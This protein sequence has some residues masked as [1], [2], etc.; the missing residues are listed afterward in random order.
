MIVLNR[1]FYMILVLLFTTDVLAQKQLKIYI[2]ADMEGVAGVV[3]SAQLGPEGF[4][5]ER[6]REFMSAEV[7]TCITAL[8]E[9]G[10]GEILISDSHGNGQ[11]LLIEKFPADVQLVRA[12]PRPLAMMQGIDD[13]F[14]GVIFLG[15]HTSTTNRLG[16][17]AHTMSSANLT[18]VRLNGIEMP[19][20]G[21]NAAIAGQFDVPVIMISGDDAII[22]ETRSLLGDVE[23]AIV[24][25]NYGFHSAKVL[26]PEA[27]N[28]VIREKVKAAIRRIDE[29]EPYNLE[30]PLRLEVSLKNYRPVELLGYLPIVERIDSHTVRF[31]GKD[32]E[33]ISRFL[34]F[35][36]NYRVSLAP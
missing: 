23:G 2:S 30:S 24:K 33:E 19:E 32:M 21:I 18:A 11:N 31:I 29:F 13:T 8:K 1:V 16:V 36:L 17:R 20:A 25:W 9:M 15:Y 3:T 7:N 34:Q 6:F 10:V 28:Q 35:L 12:W 22:E 4:E 5:Y 27:A 14:D 26:T